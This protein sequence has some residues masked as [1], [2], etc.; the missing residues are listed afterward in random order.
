M[1]KD[2][3]PSVGG[4]I[5]WEYRKYRKTPLGK[6][7]GPLAF[8]VIAA[9]RAMTHDSVLRWAWFLFVVFFALALARTALFMWRG[10]TLVGPHGI[11]AR[12]ALTERTHAWPAIYDIR[13]EP[14]PNA[15]RYARRWLTYLYDTEGRRFL[16]PHLDDWQLDNPP[17]E[18]AGLLAAGAQYR[19]TAWAR[20]P[21]VEALIQRR[22][23]HRRAWRWAVVATLIVFGC[24]SVLSIG[25]LMTTDGSPVVLL[26]LLIPLGAFALF[27]ALFHACWK[28]L[29]PR[30]RQNA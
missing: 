22:A 18:A 12:R 30:D 5:E 2:G 20:R 24:M 19:G 7:L 10:R 13:A 25:L 17:A 9:S 16:L 1:D 28:L 29:V 6:I 14:I 8:P 3:T 23:A 27:S 11:T 21:E 15:S 4:G 26:T